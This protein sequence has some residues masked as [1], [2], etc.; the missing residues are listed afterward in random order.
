MKLNE[1][2]EKIFKLK[3]SKSREESWKDACIRGSEY[4]S[5]AEDDQIVWM[6]KFF[7]IIYEQYFIPG[8]RILANSGTNIKSLMNCFVLPIDD[9]RE[10][11]YQTLKDAAEVFANGGGIGYNFSNT[12]KRTIKRSIYAIIPFFI[13]HLL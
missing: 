13:R 12:F 9:S 8:G 2:A 6:K 11:I 7:D 4:V 1:I 3:Y 10:S 5:S